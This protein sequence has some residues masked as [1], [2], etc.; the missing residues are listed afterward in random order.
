MNDSIRSSTTFK[1]FH[2]KKLRWCSVWWKI[3][4][5]LLALSVHTFQWVFPERGFMG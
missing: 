3:E 1:D 2:A 5:R 4:Y